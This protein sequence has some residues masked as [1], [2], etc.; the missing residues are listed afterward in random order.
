MWKHPKNNLKNIEMMLTTCLSFWK[1][2]DYSGA[3][4]GTFAENGGRKNWDNKCIDL[5][6]MNE[7]L[8][9]AV[10]VCDW[11]IDKNEG[12]KKPINILEINVSQTKSRVVQNR[13][14]PAKV[15]CRCRKQGA[16]K[17]STKSC[18]RCCSDSNCARHLQ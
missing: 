18:L 2:S 16:A 14:K 12:N 8:D 3:R 15:Y 11:S 13:Q 5:K 4:A 1:N 17:C 10:V 6:K 9:L 7:A